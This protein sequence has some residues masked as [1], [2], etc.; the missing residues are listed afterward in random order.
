[1]DET[2]A[3]LLL[4]DGELDDVE[5]I[6]EDL[7]VSFWRTRG[8]AIREDTAPPTQLLVS[9]P[10]RVGS[11]RAPRAKSD[12]G[13]APQRVVI[14]SEDSPGLRR[15]LR[16]AGVD[17]LVRR[18]VHREAL[19]LLV[20]DCLYRGDERRGEMRV[21]VGLDV[22]FRTGLLP[23]RALLTDLSEGGCRLLSPYALEP[24]TKLR[25]LIPE[26]MGA[27]EPLTVEG[28]VRR[29]KLVEG[30]GIDGLYSAAVEFSSPPAEQRRDLERIVKSRANGRITMYLPQAV[31]ADSVEAESGSAIHISEAK[32]AGG[33][34]TGISLPVEVDTDDPGGELPEI[35]GSN[36]RKRRR[37]RYLR[38]ITAFGTGLQVLI[39]RDLSTGGM[40]V[41]RG[42]SIA[43]GE[44]LQLAIYGE[45]GEEP[46]QVWATV[47]RDDGEA[48]FALVFDSLSPELS[49]RLERLVA[50]LPAVEPLQEGEAAAMGTVITRILHS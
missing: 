9:T 37:A 6:L 45:R 19:R 41:A 39:G 14:S 17:F 48:G 49:A 8:Q 16:S 5:E 29:I 12:R 21:P 23:R 10:R 50:S 33:D 40:R 20:L 44:R 7:G 24:G 34:P 28:R 13:R 3:V 30:P 43:V 38:E 36:R 26:E 25:V 22:S 31:S 18:P 27:P 15:Q 2:T 42:E 32:G 1:M 47:D 35:D 4:D 46:A 11:V